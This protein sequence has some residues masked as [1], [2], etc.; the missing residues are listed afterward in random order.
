MANATKRK[1]KAMKKKATGKRKTKVETK[2]CVAEKASPPPYS[3]QFHSCDLR[4]GMVTTEHSMAVSSIAMAIEANAKA[5]EEL[6]K[7]LKRSN[8]V[9]IP[10][11]K[12]GV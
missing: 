5:C 3:L 9:S 12:M 8:D 6:A 11:P 2:D 7:A 1:K 10:F 4:P